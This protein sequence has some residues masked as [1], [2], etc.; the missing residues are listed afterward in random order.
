MVGLNTS[1]LLGEELE[2]AKNSFCCKH[3]HRSVP[4]SAQR[5]GLGV[6]SRVDLTLFLAWIRSLCS[7]LL[8]LSSLLA[9][10]N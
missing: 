5:H 1:S 6:F 10:W 3:C 8:Y 4:T 2:E 7:S 9:T